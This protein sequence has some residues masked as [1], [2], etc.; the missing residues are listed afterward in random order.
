MILHINETQESCILPKRTLKACSD[1][2]DRYGVLYSDNNRRITIKTQKIVLNEIDT[3]TLFFDVFTFFETQI[4]YSE[5]G[6]AGCD[7]SIEM[8]RATYID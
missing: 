7:F 1:I 2:L 5:L 3:N 8:I 6:G 4:K